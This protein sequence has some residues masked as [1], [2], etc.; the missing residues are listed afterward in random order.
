M[1]TSEDYNYAYIILNNLFLILKK[2]LTFSTFFML[3]HHSYLEEKRTT[4]TPCVYFQMRPRV[5]R[6]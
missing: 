1:N 3:L 2:V 6:H 4:S 5:F